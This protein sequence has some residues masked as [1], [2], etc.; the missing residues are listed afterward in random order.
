MRESSST[1]RA[2][3]PG[4]TY[5]VA[6]KL[7]YNKSMKPPDVFERDREWQL[8]DEYAT[9]S[10]A[11]LG[12]VTGRRR[13]GKTFLLRR[14]AER[15]NGIFIPCINEEREPAL[16]RFAEQL[17]RHHGI[18]LGAPSDWAALLAQATS[19]P[20][21]VP[22]LIIDEFA[23][24]L[25]HSP[26]VESVLQHIVDHS[27]DQNGTRIILSGSSLAVMGGLLGGGRPLRGRADLVLKLQPFDFRVSAAFWKI[28]DASVAF[29]VHAVLGGSPGYKSLAPEPPKTVT[30]FDDWI[31]RAL[32]NPAASL[33]REDTYLLG[34]DRRV[35]ERSI[36]SN[37]LNS[38]ARG[39]HRPSRIAGR[40][41][42]AQTSLSHVF[43][44]L[45]EAGFIDN[46]DGLLSGRDPLYQLSD[47]I[48]S[49]IHSCVE[50]W[51]PLAEDD[52]REIA[53]ASA[54][55]GWHA[56]VLGP[57]LEYIARAWATRFASKRT[58]GGTAGLVGRAEIQDRE[59]RQAAEMDVVVLRHGEKIGNQAQVLSIGEAKLTADIDAVQHLDRCSD[60]LEQRGNGRPTKKIVF[61]ERSTPQLRTLL[62]QRTDVELVDLKRL[63][64]GD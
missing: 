55:D 64:A 48:I 2:G 50:P 4:K 34:E 57:H 60:L 11:N 63:Y 15:H 19:G 31:V 41:G 30:A 49:F 46:N 14:L 1:N 21:A 18:E 29:R 27:R 20:L 33:F 47:P 23:Y 53:W 42:R 7:E 24:L 52:R 44:V 61:C 35:A 17:G 56:Q 32:I 3:N 6:T 51:R 12:I 28:K 9:S 5:C 25:E 37:V 8:L 13:V 10:R 26:E 43:K 45:T 62:R 54:T 59:N 16:R 22:L 39:D 36:Y 40:V 58:I 38:I